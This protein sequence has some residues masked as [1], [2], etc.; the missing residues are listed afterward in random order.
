MQKIANCIYYAINEITFSIKND[1]NPEIYCNL[2]VCFKLY[3]EIQTWKLAF[4]ITMNDIH[5]RM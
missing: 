4:L 3:I 5:D 1:I 2:V